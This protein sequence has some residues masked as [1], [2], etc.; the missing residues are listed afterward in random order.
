MCVRLFY[1][2]D[3]YVAR[4]HLEAKLAKVSKRLKAL[5]IRMDTVEVRVETEL[6]RREASELK[7]DLLQQVFVSIDASV[8][9]I[10]FLATIL[11]LLKVVPLLAA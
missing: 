3:E 1:N 6:L 4:E 9:G 5:D 7:A 2:L 10:Q 11:I 8:G